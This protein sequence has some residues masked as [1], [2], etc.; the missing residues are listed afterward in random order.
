[1]GLLWHGAI[2][3]RAKMINVLGRYKF[4]A[5]ALCWVERT[6]K[7]SNKCYRERSP[8]GTNEAHA[9][10]CTFVWSVRLQWI[11]HALGGAAKKQQLE[12]HSYRTC[13]IQIQEKHPKESNTKESSQIRNPAAIK[14]A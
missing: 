13:F 9:I 7:G 8:E 11:D 4:A 2:F 5:P 3:C 6:D 12:L 1:M 10:Q 14:N